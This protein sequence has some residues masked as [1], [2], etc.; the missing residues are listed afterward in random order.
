MRNSFAKF[1]L[2]GTL[3]LAELNSEAQVMPSAPK[4]TYFQEIKTEISLPAQA[5]RNVI[6]LFKT[7]NKLIAVTSNGVF[8]KSDGKWTGKVVGEE[9]QAATLDSKG[10]IWLASAHS[11]QNEGGTT[12]IY[13]P[14]S[15]LKDTIFCLLWENDQ[16]LQVATTSGLMTYTNK[17][18][19]QP[20]FKGKRVNSLTMGAGNELWAA[21][22]DGLFRRTARGWINLDDYLMANGNRRTYLGLL[23]QKEGSEI[24][25]SSPYS[26]GCIAENGNHW[27]FRGADGLPYGPVTT[28]AS[29]KE[30]LWLGT[31]KGAVKKDEKWHYYHGK[32]W[33]SGNKVN[34]ILSIDEH[35]VWIATPEGISQIQEIEMTLEQ[36]AAAFEER[37]ELRHNR[38][39]LINHSKLTI[40]GDLS[41]SK[42]VNED[43]DGLWT[44]TYLAAECFRY[45]VTKDPEAKKL[46]TRTWEALERLETVTGISGYPARSYAAATDSVTQ[47]RSPHPKKWHPSPDGKWQWLDDT[48]SDEIVGHMFAI[49]LFYD[50]VADTK[51]KVKVEE[52]IERILNHIIDNNFHLIDL[53]G[54]P[55]R[56]G[57]W[58]PDSLNYSKR[59]AYERGLNSL[60]ILSSLK[61][62]VR[63]TGNPKY[64]KTYQFLIKEHGYAQN[65]LQAKIYGP[66]ENSHSDDILNFFPYYNL[67]RYGKND[68]WLNV[69]K[70]SLERSWNV[71]RAD[72]MPMWNMIAGALLEKDCDIK[73]AVEELQLYPMDLINWTMENKHRWDFECDQLVDRGGASQAT[74]PIPTPEGNISRWNTNPRQF[75]SGGNGTQEEDGTYFL[76]PYWMGRYH[77]LIAEN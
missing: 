8:K 30:S 2:I 44:S 7:Q 60:Q 34:D 17:W 57:I 68:P 65:A 51:Q 3:G 46:A 9:W 43:N 67:I 42:T 36:K 6:K 63:I 1:I 69:Y 21:T 59:W 52:L 15:A 35:M 70:Q 37:I 61:T 28:I 11:I 75:N 23:S 10:E 22:N 76:L 74:I 77:K 53:D 73:V 47:S 31:A 27:V 62:A 55:T 18:S 71:T 58:N 45:A 72:R 4:S 19:I 13:L 56:W 20:E 38:R 26:V 14:E 25:Y 66:Y 41:S 50:L 5:G 12:K 32:R 64:E 16:T 39:G 40:P 54:K 24:L 29:N 33:I 48:S 49:S